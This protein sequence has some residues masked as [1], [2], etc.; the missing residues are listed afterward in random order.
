VTGYGS[1]LLHAGCTTASRQPLLAARGRCRSARSGGLPQDA[2][3]EG[4]PPGVG[5]PRP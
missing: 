1:P 2:G 3:S 5:S 4:W